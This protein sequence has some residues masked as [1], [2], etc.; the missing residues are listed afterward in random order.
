MRWLDS[1]TS[2][3][4]MTLSKLQD[5]KKPGIL[6]SMG[7]QR[8]VLNLETEQQPTTFHAPCDPVTSPCAGD[9]NPQ[10]TM[11][12]EVE[13][14]VKST[15]LIFPGGSPGPT[16]HWVR[17]HHLWHGACLQSEIFLSD[18]MLM[19]RNRKAI[20]NC[21]DEHEFS[22]HALPRHSSHSDG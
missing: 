22:Q 1:I 9:R 20:C 16:S 7:S 5:I 19:G 8:V 18:P 4:D 13:T 14:R 12:G 17:P 15:A 3:I 6:Q 2:S 11:R 21:T 10:T